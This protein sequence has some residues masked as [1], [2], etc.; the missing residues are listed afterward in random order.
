MTVDQQQQFFMELGRLLMNVESDYELI[1][2]STS[3]LPEN[4]IAG[5]VER[6]DEVEAME[7]R[8]DDIVFSLGLK[9]RG[10]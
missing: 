3:D 1:A 10:M 9:K 2:D 5:F 4:V 6:A 8:I 7:A